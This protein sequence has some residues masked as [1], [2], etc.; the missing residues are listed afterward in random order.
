MGSHTFRSWSF[1]EGQ[2]PDSGCHHFPTR[3]NASICCHF[4]RVAMILGRVRQGS[5]ANEMDR[6][7]DCLHADS[8]NTRANPAEVQRSTGKRGC[9]SKRQ[10][11]A[12]RNPGRRSRWFGRY[13]CRGSCIGAASAPGQSRQDPLCTTPRLPN[14]AAPQKV[15]ATPMR[16]HETSARQRPSTSPQHDHHG[17][18]FTLEWAR[19]RCMQMMHGHLAGNICTD[20]R[21]R[22]HRPGLDHPLTFGRC[23][24]AAR[25]WRSR[26]C[27][28]RARNSK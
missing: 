25:T 11:P 10:L 14:T 20:F 9:L 24:Q 3:R 16:C 21:T 5:H 17:R 23:T 15:V 13:A 8:C 26:A 6:T 27:V 22:R 12:R 19:L 4:L 1:L 28:R 7:V 18:S 2:I